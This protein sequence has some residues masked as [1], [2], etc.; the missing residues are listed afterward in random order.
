MP[1]RHLLLGEPALQRVARRVGREPPGVSD[2]V[3]FDLAQPA[4]RCLGAALDA[5]GADGADAAP[6]HKR[7]RAKRL[8]IMLATTRAASGS[9]ASNCC[10]SF[11][12]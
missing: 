5:D 9:K 6:R 2:A 3:D 10:A 7:S 12:K 4:S 11:V 1:V 8:A